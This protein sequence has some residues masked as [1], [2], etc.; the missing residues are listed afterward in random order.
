MLKSSKSTAV[1]TCKPMLDTVN[2]IPQIQ[3]AIISLLAIKLSQN[4]K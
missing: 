1:H 3:I 2:I 4:K